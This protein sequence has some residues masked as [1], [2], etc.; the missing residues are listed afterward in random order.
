M[1]EDRG[2]E[3]AQQDEAGDKYL[4]TSNF[5]RQ[6]RATLQLPMNFGTWYSQF[7][8]S[9]GIITVAC[10]VCTSSEDMLDNSNYRDAGFTG[11]V[12]RQGVSSVCV[13][14]PMS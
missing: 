7:M 3:A 8:F 1:E 2:G 13:Y 11:W 5:I 14:I 12:Q 9:L 6:I 10:R 4:V